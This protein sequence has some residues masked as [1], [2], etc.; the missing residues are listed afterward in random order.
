MLR[1]GS[2]G[3]WTRLLRLLLVLPAV[4]TN[5]KPPFRLQRLEAGEAQP[6]SVVVAAR[7][8]HPKN[9]RMVIRV[10][11]TEQVAVVGIT[12]IGFC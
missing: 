11:L 5:G 1:C 3:C 8:R 12:R 10:I 7:Q 9:H 2:F 4:R 6:P